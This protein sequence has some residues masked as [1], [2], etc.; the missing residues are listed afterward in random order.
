[1]KGKREHLVIVLVVLTLISITLMAHQAFAAEAYPTGEISVYV[2]TAPGGGIDITGR[3]FCEAMEKLLGKPMVVINKVGAS[4]AIATSF[5]V[6]S[7]PDG[8]TLLWNQSAQ[9]IVKKL[10]DPSVDYSVDKLTFFGSA[11]KQY[12]FLAVNA[13]SPWK[14]YEEFVDYAKKNPIKIGQIGNIS[15]ETCRTNFLERLYNFKKVIRVPYAGGS[16]AARALLAGELDAVNQANP[17]SE[18]V[19][20]GDLRFLVAFSPER[21]PVFPNVPSIKEREKRFDLFIETQTFLAGP[22]GLPPY[23]VDKLTKTFKETTLNKEVYAKVKD[24]NYSYG[25]L[26]PQQM[27]EH[28]KTNERMYKPYVDEW[29]KFKSKK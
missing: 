19:L 24:S 22:K 27:A 3:T 6:N 4:T 5:V 12:N 17:A 1:M 8:Y 21:S 2:G 18:Y 14:T 10:E 29:L 7:K 16:E 28:W 11:H 9:P 13:K 25:Y 20:S 26:T 23:V 15:A